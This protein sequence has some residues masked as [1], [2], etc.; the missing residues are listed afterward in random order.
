MPMPAASS[1]CGSTLDVGRLAACLLPRVRPGSVGATVA[2][3]GWLVD[4]NDL[5]THVGLVMGA[6]AV[7]VA[8]RLSAPGHTVN[9][10]T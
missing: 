8:P 10:L 3:I 9:S 5:W 1:W 6:F 2:R 4:S 7:V